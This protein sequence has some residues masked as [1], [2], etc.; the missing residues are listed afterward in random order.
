MFIASSTTKDRA[1]FGGAECYSMNT[2][3][4]NSARPNGA[5]LR[6]ESGL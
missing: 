6:G 5:G 3:N 1:P 2:V 4:L